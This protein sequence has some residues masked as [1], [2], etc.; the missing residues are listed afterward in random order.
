MEDRKLKWEVEKGRK[1]A[2]R[3]IEKIEKI[4]DQNI[5]KKKDLEKNIKDVL[6]AIDELNKING[7]DVTPIRLKLDELLK[8][9]EAK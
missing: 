2:D 4:R 6:K 9:N 1:R 3:V 5:E 7:V 8:I